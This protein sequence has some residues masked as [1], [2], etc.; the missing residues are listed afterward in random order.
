MEVTNLRAILQQKSIKWNYARKM[1]NTI[2]NIR[3][4][5]RKETNGTKQIQAKSTIH[6]INRQILLCAVC[7]HRPEKHKAHTK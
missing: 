1:S 2:E 3:N 6:T 7:A 5:G 4:R